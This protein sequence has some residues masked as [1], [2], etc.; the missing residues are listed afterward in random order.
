[1]AAFGSGLGV[2]LDLWGATLSLEALMGMEGKCRELKWSLINNIII[3]W[4]CQYHQAWRSRGGDPILLFSF[5][6][7]CFCLRFLIM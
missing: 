3:N 1:M 6:M 2:A 5:L 7:N 4:E